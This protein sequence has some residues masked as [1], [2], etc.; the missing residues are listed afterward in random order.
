MTMVRAVTSISRMTRQLLTRRRSGA[1]ELP[2]I[3]AAWVAQQT[4]DRPEHSPLDLG[5]ELLGVFVSAPLPRHTPF[6]RL[7]MG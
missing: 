6:C 7:A 4:V 5:V 1:L 2:Q 3:S